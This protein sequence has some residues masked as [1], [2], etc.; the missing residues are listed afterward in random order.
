MSGGIYIKKFKE[1]LFKLIFV[2]LSGIIVLVTVSTLILVYIFLNSLTKSPLA[3]VGYA[4]AFYTLAVVIIF[5]IFGAKGSFKRAKNKIFN[6]PFINRFFSDIKYKTKV[7][8]TF[9]LIMNLLFI[10]FNVLSCILGG[11]VWF[12]VLTAYYTILAFMRF[13]LLRYFLGDAMD[14]NM[15]FQH[16]RSLFCG[17]VMLLLNFCLLAALLLIIYQNKGYEYNGILIYIMVGY[18]FIITLQSVCNLVKYRKRKSPVIFTSKV[19]SLSAALTSVLATQTAM[20]ARF[21]GQTSMFLRRVVISLSGGFVLS[22][23]VFMSV[24]L[25][26]H[27]LSEIKKIKNKVRLT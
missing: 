16:R 22:A 15:L 14:K 20:F 3:R 24:Y 27:S 23:Q 2:P 18:T 7:S 13:T 17:G 4:F 11:S 26:I 19:I 5:F 25:I 12:F 21:G 1:I 6:I 8:L 10:G 9:S